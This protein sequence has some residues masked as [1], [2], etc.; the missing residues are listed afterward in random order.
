MG[1]SFRNLR[2][3]EQG[4]K[5]SMPTDEN[6]LTGRECPNP[7]CLGY[8]KIKFG[9]G[10]KGENLPCHCPYCG[11]TAGH[12][13]FW[14]QEQLDYASS[15]MLNEVSKALKD[16]VRDWDRN[17]RQ[18]T[19][20]SFIKLSMD[21]KGKS[22]PIHY[23]RE[24]R[25]ETNIVCDHCTLEYAIYG[26][27]AF[28]PDCGDHNSLQI[29]HKNLEMIEKEISLAQ[30]SDDVELGKHLIEDALENAVSA[31]DGFGRAT[32]GAYSNKASD[33]DKAKEISFQNIEGARKKVQALFGL[34]L[35]NDINTDD[36]VF[37]VR[38]FQKRHLLAHKMGVI[39]EEYVKKA[40]DAHAI[41]GR[42]ITIA[43]AEVIK[44]LG[45]LKIIGK[46]FVDKLK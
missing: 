42:K 3:L 29:L 13:H 17:L 5:V 11:H 12:D 33:P 20:N 39:D 23:Y 25:L 32:T 28:C 6:G 40:Q 43:P 46:N 36:W 15:I 16:D 24:K 18:S 30:S 1:N 22:H 4:I 31:F 9:T 35:A 8:F 26:V 37:L 10:L 44:L 21:F 34:D 27:F 19:K 7:D 41:V 14:T 2:R 45:L 38:C